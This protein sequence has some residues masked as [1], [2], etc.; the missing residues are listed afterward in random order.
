MSSNKDSKRR[1]SLPWWV[2]FVGFFGGSFAPG[3]YGKLFA[4]MAGI[5]LAL[6]LLGLM[7]GK[8][9]YFLGPVM[10]IFCCIAVRLVSGSVYMWIVHAEARR[11]A[12]GK[13]CAV[14]DIIVHYFARVWET[15]LVFEGVG[16]FFKTWNFRDLEPV[17]RNIQFVV[18]IIGIILCVGVAVFRG[19]EKNV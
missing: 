17:A 14:R 2:W 19:Q 12:L 8:K 4:T 18:L 5:A 11:I 15:I 13:A 7:R 1:R 3:I 9:R 16:T 6:Y 10:P